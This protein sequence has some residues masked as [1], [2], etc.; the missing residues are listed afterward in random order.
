MSCLLFWPSYFEDGSPRGQV[1]V[2]AR[3]RN[4]KPS[5]F[6]NEDLAE[7]DLRSRLLFIGLWCLADRE[8]RLEDRPK[9]IKAELFPYEDCDIN[10]HLQ[11]LHDSGFIRRYEMY[12]ERY[13]WIV[14]FTKHQN[15]HIKEKASM[16]PAP[17]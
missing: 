17:D 3:A 8:G 11:E 1:Y 13:I 12:G 14:K 15:P 16:I 6:A 9:R 10:E 5:F 4:I 7:L 2:M